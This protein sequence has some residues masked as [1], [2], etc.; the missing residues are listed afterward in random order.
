[1]GRTFALYYKGSGNWV[2]VSAVFPFTTGDLL[3]ER[4]DES[5]VVFFDRVKAHKPLT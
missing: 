3:D 2:K 1:M 5:S 4:L